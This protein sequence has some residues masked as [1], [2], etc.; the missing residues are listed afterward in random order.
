MQ[1]TFTFANWDSLQP[2][3]EVVARRHACLTVSIHDDVQLAGPPQVVL[4]AL[5]D[6]ITRAREQCGL[7]PTGHKF[8]L[9]VPAGM[10]GDV[11]VHDIETQIEAWTPAAALAR[12]ERCVAQ[13]AGVVA[14]GWCA[15]GRGGLHRGATPMG[16]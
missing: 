7:E 3:L 14:G 8:G 9:Y 1:P 16:S 5:R 12:G 10:L 6:I 4:A 11:A 15:A 13:S 2:V